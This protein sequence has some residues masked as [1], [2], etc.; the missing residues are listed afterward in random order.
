MNACEYI[1]LKNNSCLA[2]PCGM[3]AFYCVDNLYVCEKHKDALKKEC[4]SLNV[5]RI[6][7]SSKDN[8]RLI[9]SK[10]GKQ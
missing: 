3:E 6:I 8:L 4:P 5:D 2:S 10:E 9:H 7:I 1:E